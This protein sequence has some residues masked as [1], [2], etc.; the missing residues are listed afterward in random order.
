MTNYLGHAGRTCLLGMRLARDIRLPA[1]QRPSLYYAL[2]L[3]DAGCSSSSARM[4]EIFG[5]VD[6][7]ELKRAGKL[8]DFSRPSEALRFVRD[9]AGPAGSHRGVRDAGWR[10][11]LSHPRRRLVATDTQGSVRSATGCAG[12]G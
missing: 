4:S 9:H 11:V 5:G 6:D 8:V 12:N 1:A 7:L 2:L 3:K 10:S